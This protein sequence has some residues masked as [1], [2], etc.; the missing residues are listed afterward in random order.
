MT[1]LLLAVLLSA[2]P[3]AKKDPVLD[4]ARALL[5]AWALKDGRRVL[6][7]LDLSPGVMTGPDVAEVCHDAGCAEK[8]L[9]DSFSLF[10][11]A[12]FGE[13]QVLGLQ[14]AA[15]LAVAVF[16]VPMETAVGQEKRTQVQ[17]FAT[18]WRQ[19]GGEW[20]VVQLVRGTPTVQRSAKEILKENV[21]K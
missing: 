20:K 14:Q 3:E 15:G 21:L 17:R 13:L 6:A 12:K 1:A 7:M 5:N 18:T 8:L 10:D 16:D 19:A 11:S 9:K 2:P 4:R